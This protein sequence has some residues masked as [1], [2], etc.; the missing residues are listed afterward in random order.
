MSFADVDD[1]TLSNTCYTI[2]ECIVNTENDLKLV[3]AWCHK[4]GHYYH[5]TEVMFHTKQGTSTDATVID[6]GH[7][8][9][10]VRTRKVL[11]LIIDEDQDL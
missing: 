5:K 4:W 6:I 7:A 9:P 3:K 8:L 11:G 2:N 10:K 1:L